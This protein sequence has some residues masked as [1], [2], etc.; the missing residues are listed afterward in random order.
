[1][2]LSVPSHSGLDLLYLFYVQPAFS[3]SAV[4]TMLKKVLSTAQAQ[5]IACAIVLSPRHGDAA[6]TRK[7]PP[8]RATSAL[9]SSLASRGR[10]RISSSYWR[11]PTCPDTRC[12]IHYGCWQALRSYRKATFST[13]SRKDG[14]VIL[15]ILPSRPTRGWPLRWLYA[16]HQYQ[17]LKSLH[18]HV[19]LQCKASLYSTNVICPWY[20]EYVLR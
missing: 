20:L 8:T 5:D 17:R 16:K 15:F 9:L 11:G 19:A 12:S 6:K 10:G 13:S 18:H 4:Y 14:V 1:M 2:W 7:M 3:L